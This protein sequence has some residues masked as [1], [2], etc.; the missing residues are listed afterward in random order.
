MI[1]SGSSGHIFI[2]DFVKI[3]TG[4][5]FRIAKVK[6]FFRKVRHSLTL[7]GWIIMFFMYT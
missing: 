6:I 7:K 2:N 5:G 1:S 4:G 3:V